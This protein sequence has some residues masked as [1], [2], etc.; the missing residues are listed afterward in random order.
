[1]TRLKLC[2]VVMIVMGVVVAPGCRLAEQAAI[3]RAII[4]FDN[5]LSSGD[6][7]KRKIAREDLQIF[8]ERSS[9]EIIKAASDLDPQV[10]A[11]TIRI[12]NELQP[13]REIFLPI[14]MKGLRDKKDYVR[15]EA[16]YG[17]WNI[18]EDARP[19][20][21]LLIEALNDRN[22]WVRR[23]AA[24]ALGDIGLDAKEAAPLIIELLDHEESGIR[25]TS[26]EALVKIDPS[27]ETAQSLVKLI[28]DEDR[29]VRGLTVQYLGMIGENAHFAIPRII[30]ML[31]E[32]QFIADNAAYGLSSFRKIPKEYAP[33]LIRALREAENLYARGNLVYAVGSVGP[34]PEV[35]S[36]LT[37]EMNRGQWFSD[38]EG[39]VWAA[40]WLGKF[41]PEPGV[42]EALI[43]A[44]G[45]APGK[46]RKQ[47]AISLGK[48]G[49]DKD[50]VL[51]HLFNSL[52]D[53]YA[54]S[55]AGAA[56]ALADYGTDA[57]PALDR[58]KEIAGLVETEGV[59]AVE[60]GPEQM[61]YGGG[62]SPSYDNLEIARLYSAYAIM[63][64]SPEDFDAALTILIEGL[65]H[66]NFDFRNKTIKLI[67]NFGA[68]PWAIEKLIEALDDEKELN[69]RL[70]TELLGEMGEAASDALPKLKEL[71]H[72]HFTRLNHRVDGG[73]DY[74][75]AA[76]EA[77]HK[78][79]GEPFIPDWMDKLD[80]SDIAH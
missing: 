15:Q 21:P 5:R 64:L 33:D 60:D 10:R 52:Y 78:I 65:N 3:G 70:A 35:I 57:L 32:E 77:I 20:M 24:G 53:D 8:W 45:N 31:F 29:I 43:D 9:A 13:D 18:G 2:I 47:A 25:E 59:I 73:D 62:G 56:Y 28:D 17:L 46:V 80:L 7:E 39:G 61:R 68:E 4:I 6:E 1:M 27:K 40:H 22:P 34:E 79:T 71:A 74:S 50:I 42:A 37:E 54:Q 76:R 66:D 49:L 48:L 11:S 19:A 51:P 16:A 41:G 38:G 30:E 26:V 72:A 23:S 63:K 36:A 67:G 44:L 69:R 58:L 75:T 55:W 14:L 12:L